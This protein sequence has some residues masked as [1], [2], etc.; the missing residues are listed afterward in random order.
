MSAQPSAA[1][2]E[3]ALRTAALTALSTVRDPELDEPI[4]DL[5]FVR[6][7]TITG[8]AVT[9]RLRLP[10]SFCAPNFAY[11]M[12]SDAMDAL[13]S[14]PGIGETTV[15]LDENVD[16]ERINAGVA[17]GGGFANA[18]PDES[19][20]ELDALRR[21]FQAKAH[22]A[23]IERVAALMLRDYGMDVDEVNKL[24]L[25]DLPEHP[26]VLALLNRRS[27]LGLPTGPLGSV[28]INEDGSRWQ[29]RDVPL[30]L[31][32]R[33]AKATRIS[34]DGNAH[35]CRGLLRTRYPESEADQTT[36][37]QDLVFIKTGKR[38]E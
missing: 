32:L 24:V 21:I 20:E 36:R 15:E 12:A 31:Q 1:L 3:E 26:A 9:V 14:I 5:G 19:D 27:D 22:L 11:L 13:K 34:I 37:K 35:F 33:F 17:A 10:T 29:D 8:S 16:S 28:F 7:L 25:A 23:A 18:F 2:P 4:T 38:S 6:K 30:S